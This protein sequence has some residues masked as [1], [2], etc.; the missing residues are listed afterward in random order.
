[1]LQLRPEQQEP[2]HPVSQIGSQQRDLSPAT[3]IVVRHSTVG[4]IARET[5]RPLTARLPLAL[6]VWPVPI[7][8][9]WDPHRAPPSFQNCRRVSPSGESIPR[10]IFKII[11]PSFLSIVIHLYVNNALHIH[12]FYIKLHVHPFRWDFIRRF[13]VY[14]SY[15]QVEK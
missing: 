13:V 3:Y 12:F 7:L 9:V 6:G 4:K 11:S 10:P 14:G 1:M 8:R 2:D 15:F 5:K